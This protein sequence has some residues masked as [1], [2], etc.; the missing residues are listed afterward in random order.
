MLLEAARVDRQFLPAWSLAN[1][2]FRRGDQ[3]SFWPWAKR[4]AALTFDDYRPL[5]RLCDRFDPQPSE[6]IARLQGGAPLV[7]AYVDLLIGEHRLAEAKEI[8]RSLP[9][10]K[11]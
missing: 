4:A 2:Y 1:F 7:R 8:A 9:A 10:A 11:L 3:A 5:L 6:V